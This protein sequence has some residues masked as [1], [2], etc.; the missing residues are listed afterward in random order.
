VPD[1]AGYRILRSTQPGGPY[2]LVGESTVPAYTAL[3]PQTGKTYS[4]VVQAYDAHG[5]LSPNSIQMRGALPVPPVY[6]PLIR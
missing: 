1:V 5:V 3:L 4:Y 6:L 2:E